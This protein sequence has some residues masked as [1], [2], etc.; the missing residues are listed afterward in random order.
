MIRGAVVFASIS[1]A[2]ATP[3]CSEDICC[4]TIVHGKCKDNT[5]KAP[6]GSADPVA[7]TTSEIA[8]KKNEVTCTTGYK[9]K[10]NKASID[11]TTAEVCCD[12]KT[13]SDLTCASKTKLKASPTQP[14]TGK[15]PTQ[16]ECCE[17]VTGMC[18]GNKDATKDVTCSTGYKDKAN[19][20]TIAGT[21]VDACCDKKTCSD[22]TCAAKTKAKASPTQPATGADPTQ[23]ECCEDITGQCTGNKNSANDVTCPSGFPA[24]SASD[25]YDPT[26]DDTLAK[27]QLKCC[28]QPKCIKNVAKVLGSCEKLPVNFVQG[29]CEPSKGFTEK[30]NID[31]L[32]AS[33]TLTDF[34]AGTAAKDV[35]AKSNHADCCTPKTGFCAGNSNPSHDVT[36]P[37]GFMPPSASD[38]YDPTTD[39]TVAK[40]RFKCCKQPKCI[41]NVAA[42]PGSCGKPA[43]PAVKGTCDL[44]KGY[45]E[46]ADIASL[47]ADP[48]VAEWASNP[49]VKDVKFNSNLADCCTPTTGMCSGNTDS[50]KDVSCNVAGYKDKANK[51]TI[52]GTTVDACCD[53][54]TC[55]DF[56]CVLTRKKVKASPTQPTKGNNP[57]EAD[58]CEVITG[59]CS[60]N[61]DASTDA[62]CTTG[63]KDKANKATITGTTV[64]ACCDQKTCSDLMCALTKKKA[65]ASPTQ[66]AQDKE[67]VEADCCEDI[68]GQCTGNT[69]A[70]N[71][72]T[73]PSGFMPPSASDTYD[74]TTDDT[75]AKK[76]FK[77]CKR[78][79]CIKNV[80]AKACTDT[81]PAVSAIQ[82][83][84]ELYKGY[85]EKENIA[86][87][88]ADP[89]LAEWAS[90]PAAKTVT[91]R[92]N[93]ADC[94]TPTTGMCAGN[95]DS[96]KDV[97]CPSGT[98]DKA[99]KNTITGTD[100]ATCCDVTP[101]C[102]SHTTLNTPFTCPAGK[103]AKELAKVKSVT[104]VEA[105]DCVNDA[106]DV[107]AVAGVVGY[108][109]VCPIVTV[110]PTPSPTAAPTGAVADYGIRSSSAVAWSCI[111]ASLYCMV[112]N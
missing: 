81:T 97:T 56:M 43:V 70:A 37:S 107:T 42:V 22:L 6:V 57:T 17:D 46:K 55:S 2:V 85:T 94:C 77:C 34:E 106:F 71:D 74:P 13:C 58:C 65:K 103:Y 59:M 21:A 38:T 88:P 80:A 100:V 48:T 19:K 49:A 4:H 3:T 41:K 68:T 50:S 63:W 16:A 98:T 10:T 99:N 75:V 24:P 7:Y 26:A 28:K 35:S 84:C 1:G 92:S 47:P 72:V 110:A 83:T 62:T 53:Q 54:K 30:A 87:L 32:P 27:K 101:T 90:T 95:T 104:A 12:Q 67:P 45:T 73:C 69:N 39:D 18:F 29:T 36:C 105:R 20:A 23:A 61:T 9:D 40:K 78:N 31:T 52:A 91:A 25:T 44:T 93:H 109:P 102:M 64:A 15:D 108:G 82:G 76:R 96:S 5:H 111:L 112:M 11:G 14:A 8:T 51:A 79:K 89:T 60:G 86:S 33:P 66:P